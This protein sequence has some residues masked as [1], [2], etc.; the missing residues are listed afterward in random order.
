MVILEK[1]LDRFMRLKLAR[2]HLLPK[3]LTVFSKFR[4]VFEEKVNELLVQR[5]QRVATLTS[6]PQQDTLGSCCLEEVPNGGGQIGHMVQGHDYF[7]PTRAKSLAFSS[8]AAMMTSSSDR[9]VACNLFR[10][11]MT[12]R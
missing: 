6:G 1:P 3:P 12:R 7:P 10:V 4:V 2:P 11:S 9:P 5:D 8:N